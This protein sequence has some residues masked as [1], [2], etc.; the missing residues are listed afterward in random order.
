MSCINKESLFLEAKDQYLVVIASCLAKKLDPKKEPILAS[1]VKE[2][3]YANV[4]AK[5]SRPNPGSFIILGDGLKKRKIIVIYSQIY[6]SKMDYPRDNK[7][8]RLEWFVQ[9]LDGI[10]E[11]SGLKSICFPRQ[12]CRDGGGN[13]SD[14][15]LAISDFS[16]TLAL[17][18]EIQV[19]ICE[20]TPDSKIDAE[21]PNTQISLINTINL[22]TSISLDSIVMVSNLDKIK[23]EQDVLSNN[24]YSK[25][26]LKFN[27]DKFRGSKSLV[28]DEEIQS[29]KPKTKLI[30]KK[31]STEGKLPDFPLTKMNPDWFG[32]NALTQPNVDPSWSIIFQHED[33]QKKLAVTHKLLV[34]DLEKHGDQEPFLPGFE[35]I[36][37]TFQLCSWQDCRVVILGQDP[38]PNQANAMGLS[39]S[40]PEGIKTPQSLANIFKELKNEYGDEYQIPEHGNLEGWVKQGVLLLNSALT[41]RGKKSNSHQNYWRDVTTTIIRMISEHKEQ[42]V[43]FM[44]WGGDAKKKATLINKRK[45]LILESTHPS[46]LSAHRGWFGNN[47]FKICNEKLVSCGLEPINW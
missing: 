25:K 2:F 1:L 46:P 45:H 16:Q 26:K 22:D 6:P 5:P 13:W 23:V 41:I 7:R 32:Q 35:N 30:F 40:V 12:I 18:F 24:Q 38:Y 14:Y 34:A 44:L 20:T 42:P 15:Y 47:H 31:N 36:W 21:L 33:C 3:P 19:S 4:Y 28:L 37:K 9:A 10:S 29:E 43:V 39:F 8:K 27:L 17:R 11:I